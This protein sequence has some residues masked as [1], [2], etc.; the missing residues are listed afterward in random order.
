MLSFFIFWNFLQVSAKCSWFAYIFKEHYYN[1]DWNFC[2]EWESVGNFMALNKNLSLDEIWDGTEYTFLANTYKKE[3]DFIKSR[4]VLNWK[5]LLELKYK[6]EYIYAFSNYSLSWKHIFT[7]F[8]YEGWTYVN[9]EDKDTFWVYIDSKKVFENWLWIDWKHKIYK[10]YWFL[11]DFSYNN[12]FLDFK[13]LKKIDYLSEK[14]KEMEKT[15]KEKYKNILRNELKKHVD[16]EMLSLKYKLKFEETKRAYV[17]NYLLQ[18]IVIDEL[19]KER[20]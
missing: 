18:E 20:K 19:L 13:E 5:T 15:E 17:S 7:W 11:V 12:L 1:N 14:I 4:V 16:E 6:S 9:P 8:W 2:E 3:K 10:E